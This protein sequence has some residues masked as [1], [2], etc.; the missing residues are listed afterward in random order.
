MDPHFLSTNHQ[1]CNSATSGATPEGP[2]TEEG[3]FFIA[4][5]KY[6]GD[7]LVEEDL[8]DKNCMLQ[9][10]V[11]LL[12]AGK[13]F[14]DVH[15][16][17]FLPQPD[18]P[19]S[20]GLNIESPDDNPVTSSSSSSSN[21]DVTANSFVES[22]WTG[23]ES[24]SIKRVIYDLENN[25]AIPFEAKGKAL[26]AKNGGIRGKKKQHKVDGYDS[27]E[28]STKQSAFYAEECD[29][30]E[31]FDSALLCEDL[32]VSGIHIV[33]EEASFPLL[34][35][36]SKSKEIGRYRVRE[37]SM[38]ATATTSMVP[39]NRG[40]C[41]N[42]A[43]DDEKLVFETT[44]GVELIMSF[45]QMGIKNDLLRG[46][47]AYSF[48]KPSAVQQRA[49]LPIIQG[50]DVIAQAQSG[51]GKTSMFALTVYQMVDTSNREV[52]ALISSPTRELASQTEKVILAIGD[53]V[54]IQA[55]T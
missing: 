44:E 10:S 28:R 23:Q 27:E 48:E 51:T 11:A 22:D 4:M 24:Q 12:T 17:P 1:P 6:I 19:Q 30:S 53:S 33:E 2:P 47:Y 29:P 32:N 37:K 39:A 40:G 3:D 25:I 7:I 16:E 9:D 20:I 52:Q 36:K 13:S 15:G 26:E 43:V 21:S 38:A 31:V 14:Y 18:S 54:N 49:V 55:H 5:Y 34:Q 8:E 35:L 42:S 46:I 45:D 41:R 50:H